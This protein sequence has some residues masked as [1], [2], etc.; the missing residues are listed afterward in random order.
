MGTVIA[1]YTQLARLSEESEWYWAFELGGLTDE[2]RALL[3]RAIGALKDAESEAKQA[4]LGGEA[5]VLLAPNDQA[6]ALLQTYLADRALEL[7]AVEFAHAGA[8]VPRYDKWDVGWRR[9]LI[10]YIRQRLGLENRALRPLLSYEVA[11]LPNKAKIAILGDWGTGL[12]GARPCAETIAEEGGYHALLHLGDVYYSGSPSELRNNFLDIWAPMRAGSPDAVSRACNSN[13]EMFSGGGPFFGLTLPAFGQAST[14]FVLDNDYWMF[15]GMDTAYDDHDLD[16][17][18]VRWLSGV[19]AGLDERRLVLLSHH[20]PF[21]LLDKQGPK[22]T[23]RL[24][25]L[26]EQRRISA[27][28]WGHE[29]LLAL[30]DPHPQWELSGRCVGHGGFPYLRKDKDFMEAATLPLRD[31]QVFRML[32]ESGKVPGARVLDGPNDY[33]GDRADRY[34][35]NGFMRLQ[36]EGP[37]LQEEVVTPAGVVLWQDELR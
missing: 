32:P 5:D 12:Y 20:Q 21:S 28:Y 33:L 36:I 30:Y 3:G 29:H 13:H 14:A 6:A 35:P 1:N 10:P 16:D 22:L 9:A 15:V 23:R 4:A 11:T 31:R 24:A 8:L 26:L 25:D 2:D 34:G 17:D 18:Q 7:G 19:L 27:W 37:F